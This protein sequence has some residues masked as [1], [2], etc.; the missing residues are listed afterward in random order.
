MNCYFVYLVIST[1]IIWKSCISSK[2]MH[3]CKNYIFSEII[4]VKT[5]RK[6]SATAWKC[7]RK[8]SLLFMKIT[9]PEMHLMQLYS[10]I[11]VCS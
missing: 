7:A 6:G 1:T 3:D 8:D 10:I 9:T 11:N 5:N 4:Y 2:T